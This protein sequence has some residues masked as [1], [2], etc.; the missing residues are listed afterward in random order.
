MISSIIYKPP[1]L[2]DLCLR[3]SPPQK[4]TYKEYK[5]QM[6]GHHLIQQSSGTMHVS[7]LTVAAEQ[8]GEDS[9]DQTNS[10]SSFRIEAGLYNV[11]NSK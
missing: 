1:I 3:N 6:T 2:G 9:S 10:D 5:Q 4:K 7:S 11:T 8:N